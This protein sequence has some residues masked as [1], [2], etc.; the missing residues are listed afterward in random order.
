MGTL[1][2]IEVIVLIFVFLAMI[3]SLIVQTMRINNEK[4]ENV[5]LTAINNSLKSKKEVNTVSNKNWEDAYN[6]QAK[7]SIETIKQLHKELDGF[8]NKKKK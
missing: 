7:A 8:K 3:L 4:I 2:S 6:E 1:S 5:K